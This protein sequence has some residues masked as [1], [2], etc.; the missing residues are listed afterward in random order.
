MS[1]I[2]PMNL[3]LIILKIKKIK[4]KK[5]LLNFSFKS[6]QSRYIP[7]CSGSL[8]CFSRLNDNNNAGNDCFVN[9]HMIITG[10]GSDLI[11]NRVSVIH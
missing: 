10:V 8:I 11:S 7:S 5:N 3:P 1:L 4:I 9:K 6:V 2:T